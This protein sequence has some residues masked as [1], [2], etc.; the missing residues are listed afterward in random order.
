MADELKIEMEP[1]T[2]AGPLNED[3]VEETED[4]LELEFA[5]E[6]IEF[7]ENHNGGVPKNQY[8]RLGSNV[9]ILE[10]FLCV[11][12]EYQENIEFGQFDIG[13]VWSQIE[14]R[15][16]E[17]LMPFA[18]VFAGDFLCFDFEESDDPTVVLWYHDRSGE[19]EP[20]TVKVADN[21][22]QFLQMLTNSEK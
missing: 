22:K 11:F 17:F 6:F 1:G 4:M 12:A 18:V 19:G 2:D 15:L 13:V 9:K 20:F 7:L 21:F 8:F 5:P 14:D 3:Y 10:R 16:N